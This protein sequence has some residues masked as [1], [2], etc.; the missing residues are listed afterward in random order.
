ME[1]VKKKKKNPKSSMYLDLNNFDQ[2]TKKKKSKEEEENKKYH[3]DGSCNL[4]AAEPDMVLI[5]ITEV[6][7]KYML[8]F[9]TNSII[10]VHDS[11]TKLKN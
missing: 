4:H 2:R 5:K 10:V 8:I 11:I 7:K 1:A 6:I 3:A 9:L